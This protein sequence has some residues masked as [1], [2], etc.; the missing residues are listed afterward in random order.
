MFDRIGGLWYKLV[1]YVS[2]LNNCIEFFVI[3]KYLVIL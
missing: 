3:I 1:K 2:I